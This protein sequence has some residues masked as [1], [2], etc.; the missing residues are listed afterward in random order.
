MFQ[1][2]PVG[3]ALLASAFKQTRSAAFVASVMERLVLTQAQDS[4]HL[5]LSL[6]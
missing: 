3:I 4:E 2:L 6:N 1:S 5:A